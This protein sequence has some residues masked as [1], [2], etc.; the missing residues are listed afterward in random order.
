MLEKMAGSLS[1]QHKKILPCDAALETTAFDL[2]LTDRHKQQLQHQCLDIDALN[3]VAFHAK[4]LVMPHVKVRSRGTFITPSMTE[5]VLLT[6]TEMKEA[7][8]IHSELK[9][10][11]VQ[12]LESHRLRRVTKKQEVD[13]LKSERKHVSQRELQ[14]RRAMR[15]EDAAALNARRAAKRAEAAR[16]KAEN[17]ATAHG[18][19][20]ASCIKSKRRPAGRP[21]SAAEPQRKRRALQDITPEQIPIQKQVSVSGSRCD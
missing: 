14:E 5:G 7:F 17:M 12:D 1:S 18:A 8:S 6:S 2:Q 19:K 13:R 21:G 11:R 20:Q 15:V 10:M 4:N 3:V 16:T 9:A